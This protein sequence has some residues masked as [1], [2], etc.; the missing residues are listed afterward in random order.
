MTSLDGYTFFSYSYA[1]P[2]YHT[3]DLNCDVNVNSIYSRY[4]A[5]SVVASDYEISSIDALCDIASAESLNTKTELN[6]QPG[7]SLDVEL[8][9]TYFPGT[10]KTD[11]V[12]QIYIDYN[13]LIPVLINAIVDLKG[14]L[15]A[16]SSEIISKQIGAKS[17]NIGLATSETLETSIIEPE[18][19]QNSPNPFNAGTSIRYTLPEDVINAE[20]YIYNLQGNQIKKYVIN[21][22]GESSLQINASELDAGMYIYALIA[23][24]KEIDTKRMIL[25]Q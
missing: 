3:L 8:L 2:H 24:G 21:E 6:K 18:L 20:I 13:K 17:T 11:S 23:D 19:Y 25:T 7:S 16:N 14:Q 9:E 15:D 4:D 1:E 22:R 10:V 5:L 12:G